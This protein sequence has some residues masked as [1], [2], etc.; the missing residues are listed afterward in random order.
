MPRRHDSDDPLPTSRSDRAC[1]RV[2]K[3][4]TRVALMSWEFRLIAIVLPA[5]SALIWSSSLG[6]SSSSPDRAALAGHTG[7]VEAVVFAP[8]GRTLAS[9][10][11]DHTVRLWDTSGWDEVPPK[12]RPTELDALSNCSAIFALAFAPDGSRLAAATDQSVTI[13]SLD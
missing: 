5:T 12:G 1:E 3:V 11:F 7:L 8:D 6:P 2:S 10:G 13:W 9:S 4:R